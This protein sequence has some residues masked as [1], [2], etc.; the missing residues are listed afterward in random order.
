MARAWSAAIELVSWRGPAALAAAY[1]A[2]AVA[3]LQ[4]AMVDGAASPIWPAAG[5]ALGGL[6]LIGWRCW[7]AIAF[8]MLAA[9]ELT[10]APHSFAV[11]IAL[12]LGNAAAAAG[13]AAALRRCAWKDVVALSARGV[14]AVLIAS[15]CTASV[16]AAVGTLSLLAAGSINADALWFVWSRWFLADG[17]GALLVVPLVLSWSTWWQSRTGELSFAACLVA[18][19]LVSWG[20]FFNDGTTLRTWHIYPVLIWAALRQT[21]FEAAAA[22][23]VMA[24]VATLGTMSGMGPIADAFPALQ[25]PVQLQQFLGITAATVLLLAAVAGERRGFVLLREANDK[26]RE[27]EERVRLMVDGLRDH[28]IYMLD[29]KGHVLSWNAGVEHLKGYTSDQ[30]VGRHFGMFFT[31]KDREAQE[32][33]ALL[34]AARRHGTAQATGTRIRADGTTFLAHVTLS[35]LHNADGSVRGFSKITRDITER[36]RIEAE[37]DASEAR[38]RAIVATAIDAVIVI[39]EEGTI[40]SANP[41]AERIFGYG[42]AELV[43]ENIRVLMPAN[44]ASAHDGYLAAYKRTG[45]AKILGVGSEVTGQR[46]DGVQVP[47]EAS[48]TEWRDLEG[49]RF[50]TG[51]L[52]DVTERKAAEARLAQANADLVAV[53]RLSAMGAMAST[54]A[55]ELNQPLTSIVNYMAAAKRRLAR[56]SNA[57]NLL[58]EV[59]AETAAEALH[60]GEIIRRIRKFTATGEVT[61]KP[62]DLGRIIAAA[63]AA[64]ASRAAD[65]RVTIKREAPLNLV[66]VDVD[67]V[68]IEQVLVN[69]LRNALDAMKDVPSGA[70]DVGWEA[71]GPEV[72]VH[73]A[74]TGPGLSPEAFQGLFQP[75]RSKKDEGMGL[76][77]PLCRTIVE[78][79]GGRI[80]ADQPVIG[81]GAVFR[82]TLPLARASEADAR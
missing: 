58:V 57:D 39:D 75:F 26:L 34:S 62:E 65:Q 32:P 14:G 37:R 25:V 38:L 16:S 7:P 45:V 2:A 1:A 42:A 8:G 17:V 77:L 74:D 5:V 13:G 44:I 22:V 9:F 27:S 70:L 71:D 6:L 60:A 24:V 81:Q 43:G 49:R 72:A 15:F 76:G 73:V 55:H 50:F 61:R 29:P 18:T 63:C 51:I 41:A 19:A 30:V 53:S 12:S 59:I 35:A 28:A 69:L 46:E 21:M 56:T 82:L 64:V 20:V 4:W 40:H 11:E 67:A 80:W 33:E 23:A 54:L 3:G 78:A 48:I 68:Q 31:P 36:N 10:S 52:R 79:H 66:S 47:L